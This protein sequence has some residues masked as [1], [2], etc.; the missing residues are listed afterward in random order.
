MDENELTDMS[1]VVG[2]QLNNV[3]ADGKEELVIVLSQLGRLISH[4][5]SEKHK[6]DKLEHELNQVS[7]TVF[8]HCSLANSISLSPLMCS[9]TRNAVFD[10]GRLSPLRSQK[11]IAVHPSL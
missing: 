10:P 7:E 6:W 5:K 1:E 4:I 8:G 11:A 3:A 2:A 9:A